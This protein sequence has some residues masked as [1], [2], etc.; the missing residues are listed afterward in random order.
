VTVVVAFVA[1]LCTALFAGASLY[2]NLIEH[3]ARIECGT[4]LAT[5]EFGPS[6]RRATLMQAFLARVGS[7]AAVST[8]WL[9]AIP[10]CL[11]AGIL[12]AAVI[13][14]TMI[15]FLPY[16]QEA[17]QS[18]FGPK[19]RVGTEPAREVGQTACGPHCTEPGGAGVAAVG[20]RSEPLTAGLV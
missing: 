10:R 17:A 3:P 13:P 11:L 19:F 6:Y 4:A 20:G 7:L 15:V 16:Q 9:T 1:T 2:I 8:W 18:T 5:T 12:V 14:F